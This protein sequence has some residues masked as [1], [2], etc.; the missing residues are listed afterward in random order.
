MSSL[1]QETVFK[2]TYARVKANG[3]KEE[4][5]ETVQRYC[6]YIFEKDI[7]TIEEKE[8]I[9][10]AILNKD[11]MPSMR[12]LLTAGDAH[13]E[14]HIAG[15][16]CCFVAI[17]EPCIF[18]EILYILMAGCGVGF[19]V[20]R[21]HINKLPLIPNEINRVD[22]TYII[23]DS[24]L[25]WA[26]AFNYHIKNLYEGFIINFD[27][28]K[29][30]PKGAPLKTFGGYASGHEVFKELI[31][32]TTGIFLQSIG[33][34]LRPIECHS[35][36]CKIG[37]IVVVGGVRRS[38]MISFS[39]LDDDEMAKAKS[40]DWYNHNVHFSL[41]NNSSVY[42]EKPNME[43]YLKEM[44]NI[45][46]SYSGER[47]FY[48]IEG[49]NKHLPDRRKNLTFEGNFYSN[50]CSEI[51]LRES[52]QMCNLTEV[53]VKPYDSHLRLLQKIKIAT[54]IGTIQSTYTDFKFLRPIYKKNCE[55]ERLLG[56]SLTGICDNHLTKN[57]N[58]LFLEQMKE[59]AIE[60]NKIY[61]NKLN[62]NTSSC[63][64]CIKPSGT[65]SALCGTSSGIHNSFSKYY[66]RRMRI[67][68]T[69]P[70]SD[71]LIRNQIPN[72]VDFYSPDSIVFSFPLT[73]PSHK[74][75]S[76]IEQFKL[77][78]MYTKHFTEHKVSITINYKPNEYLELLNDMYYEWDNMLGVALLPKSESTYKQMPFEAITKEEYEKQ[79]SNF[80]TSINWTSNSYDMLDDKITYSLQC[81]G[82][83][84]D[85]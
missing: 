33:L 35:I 36:L 62:I 12:L 32:F 74:E 45:Y 69:D 43:L 41:A 20:E 44:Y 84:C 75:M 13:R 85:L 38:A 9:Y 37:S 79:I 22:T 39:D 54:I 55:D 3:Q 14:N 82:S 72:E 40:N 50:P 15:Y 10:E 58:P 24:K 6:D 57:P 1:F 56:V 42:Y 31:D 67:S 8:Q 76:A 65:V 81:L 28:S 52:G 68:K 80:P 77:Y 29:I 61:A 49:V 60:V 51:C 23:E 7:L 78:L 30:R 83:S 73:N 63:I 5:N 70:L 21:K 25:G 2:R 53:V 26:E 48:N 19:S 18:S 59:Y 17:T 16:N 27:Y 11:V 34:K 47:G 66:I 71:I 64:T 4:W 46:K